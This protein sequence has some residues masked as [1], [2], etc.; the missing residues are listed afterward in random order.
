MR[1]RDTICVAAGHTSGETLRLCGLPGGHR[2][3]KPLYKGLSNFHGTRPDREKIKILYDVCASV[4]RPILR[5]YGVRL[6]RPI[7]NP[8]AIPIAYVALNDVCE[9]DVIFAAVEARVG[10][11]IHRARTKPES[12]RQ[13]LKQPKVEG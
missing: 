4:T 3:R 1:R 2:A 10:P 12:Q 13:I 9:P 8:R 5:I 11:E 6:S 7:R